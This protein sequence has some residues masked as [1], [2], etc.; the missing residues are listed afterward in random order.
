MITLPVYLVIDT[1]ASLG[2]DI[3]LVNQGLV[4]LFSSLQREP[5][6][7][8]TVRI[9]LIRFSSQAEELIPLTDVDSIGMIPTLHAAGATDYG[10]AFSLVRQLIVRDVADLRTANVRILRPLMFFVTDGAPIDTSWQ[11]TLRELQSPEFRAHP[12]IIAIGFGSADPGI[13]RDVGSD[14]GGA[15]MISDTTSIRDAL[16]SISSGL[17]SMLISTA[18]SSTSQSGEAPAIPLPPDWLDLSS[19]RDVL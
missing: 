1:S 8:D 16:H 6:V 12:T 14:R 10:V 15:F 2:G 7:A 3:D 13:L 9:A 17:A 5:L 4:D 11:T 19:I 18:Q